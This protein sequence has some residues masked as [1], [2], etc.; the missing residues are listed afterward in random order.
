MTYKT[1]KRL[2][3]VQLEKITLHSI[4]LMKK[5]RISPS[6]VIELFKKTSDEKIV[7]KV[8]YYLTQRVSQG[9][10]NA[11]KLIANLAMDE[12]I[13]PRRRKDA[14]EAMNELTCSA[15]NL[16]PVVNKTAVPVFTK[17]LSSNDEVLQEASARGLMNLAK[18]GESDARFG[19]NYAA[20]L[21]SK[22]IQLYASIGLKDLA[23]KGVLTTY[24]GLSSCLLTSNNP[25]VIEN[26]E[27]GII[28]LGKHN[29]P[30]VAVLL[31]DILTRTVPQRQ[32]EII[33]VLGNLA[34]KGDEK[35]FLGLNESMNSMDSK[36]RWCAINQFAELAKIGKVDESINALF[37]AV[38]D[39][40][41]VNRRVAIRALRD[42]AKDAPR[43]AFLPL[44][45]ATNDPILV[46]KNIAKN[47]LREIAKEN[48]QY[49][50]TLKEM[51]IEL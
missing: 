16:T 30:Y 41:E 15:I 33:E 45:T 50:R 27:K 48:P 23:Q 11:L 2:S 36:K 19:L 24:I 39:S 7:T 8:H 35:A 28:A 46:N 17:G 31:N 21:K 47:A 10:Q 1:A 3:Q 20:T 4:D 26:A 6:I 12:S 38:N 5:R 9:D 32:Y 34:K 51:K 25:L 14:I 29:H 44:V 22:N 42:I 40:G 43:K 37:K 18:K 13:P 49:A